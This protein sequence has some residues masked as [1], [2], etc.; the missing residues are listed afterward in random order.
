MVMFSAL[1]ES[2]ARSALPGAAHPLTTPVRARRLQKEIDEA[3]AGDFQSVHLARPG[4]VIDNRLRQ[5]TRR[6]SGGFAQD[7]GEIG[8]ELAMLR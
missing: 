4:H 6:H 1:P 7:H 3:R 5:L 2:S 8:G